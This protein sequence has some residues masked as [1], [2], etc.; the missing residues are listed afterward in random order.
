MSIINFCLVG[1]HV[2]QYYVNEGWEIVS[3]APNPC[4]Q[5]YVYFVIKKNFDRKLSKKEKNQIYE[6]ALR[7]C[8]D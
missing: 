4:P 1:D 7:Y 5:P 6:K 2:I 3:S 8:D